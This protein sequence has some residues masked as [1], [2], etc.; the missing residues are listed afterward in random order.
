M[1]SSKSSA[2]QHVSIHRLYPHLN[3]EELKQAEE[4]LDRYL[5]LALQIYDRIRQN[6]EEYA[7]FE[8]L[9]ASPADRH[10]GERQRSNI[11]FR[12]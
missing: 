10:D 8:A 12:T 7:R 6:P 3:D 5:E 9:T 11:N 4:N 1:E 2:E